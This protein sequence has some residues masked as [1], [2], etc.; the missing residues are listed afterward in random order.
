MEKDYG[1]AVSV[2]ESR[3]NAFEDL[4]RF[5]S[6]NA[7]IPMSTEALSFAKT[8]MEHPFPGA[9]SDTSSIFYENSFKQP[10]LA[11]FLRASSS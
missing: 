11:C 2:R 5:W 1:N 7:P 3:W 6:F 10:P 4:T 9:S 8:I